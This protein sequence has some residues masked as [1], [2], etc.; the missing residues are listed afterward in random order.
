MRGRDP[1]RHSAKRKESKKPRKETTLTPPIRARDQSLHSEKIVFIYHI[2]RFLDCEAHYELQRTILLKVKLLGEDLIWLVYE[3]YG[4]KSVISGSTG[5]LVLVRWAEPTDD[6]TDTDVEGKVWSLVKLLD[7]VPMTVSE[8]DS[9]QVILLGQRAP[10][11]FSW[12]NGA[13]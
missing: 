11:S 5:P 4:G 10:S 2:H 12:A 9:H 13:F 7:L 1:Y 6:T 3:A 8:A